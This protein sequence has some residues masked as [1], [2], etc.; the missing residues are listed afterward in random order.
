MIS[1][2]ERVHTNEC[3]LGQGNI[4]ILM[5]MY[6]CTI[7]AFLA[8]PSSQTALVAIDSKAV[9]ELEIDSN[10][11]C[12]LVDAPLAGTHPFRFRL[13][14]NQYASSMCTFDSTI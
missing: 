7:S 2:K 1:G 3:T 10:P 11:L 8:C 13:D 5:D 14:H 12:G 4:S 6:N 9:S